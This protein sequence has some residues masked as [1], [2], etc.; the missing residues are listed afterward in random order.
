MPTTMTALVAKVTASMVVAVEK[1]EGLTAIKD[2]LNLSDNRGFSFGTDDGEADVLYHVE[3]E[4]DA[5]QE[6][7]LDLTS[8]V[9]VYGDPI[10]FEKVDA[11]V[12]EN[13]ST[14]AATIEVG[15][16]AADA[17]LGPWKAVSQ[18]N[19]VEPDGAFAFIADEGG[20]AIAGGKLLIN[21]IDAVVAKYKLAILG[22][23][24]A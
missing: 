5:S 18:V 10:N 24:A 8:L 6:D 15:P 7:E 11:I 20:W 3:G 23:V 12:F 4:I 2:G 9:D 17:F 1:E 16:P 13:S 21:N 19:V 14:L 22:R